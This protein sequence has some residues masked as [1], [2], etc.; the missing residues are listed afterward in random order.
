M[1][2]NSFTILFST[3]EPEGSL[4]MDHNTCFTEKISLRTFGLLLLPLTIL[5]AAIGM[6]VVPLFGVLL[7][8][9]VLILTG[10]MIQAPPSD[11]CRIA[12]R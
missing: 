7:A 3:I 12:S 9:P 4:K 8:L 6:L 10:L 11:L 5:I 1:L 2:H